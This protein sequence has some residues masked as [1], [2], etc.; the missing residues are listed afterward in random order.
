M[1]Y[2]LSDLIPRLKKYSATLDQ[3][4]FLVDKP[5]VVSDNN[6]E[7]EKLIFRRDGR[8]HLSSD[9]NV[10]DGTWEYLPEAQSLLIDYGDQKKLYQHQYLDESV[11]ALKLD[12]DRSNEDYFLLANENVIPDYD[13]KKYLKIK[14]LKENNIKLL[15]LEDGREI[16]LKPEYNG[17]NLLNAQAEINGQPVTDGVY[18]DKD[19]SNKIVVSSGKVSERK[20]RVNYSNNISVW[21]SSTLPVVGDKVEGI[22]TGSFEIKA[23]SNFTIYVKNGQITKVKDDT[24]MHILLFLLF[25]ILLFIFA[26]FLGQY[27]PK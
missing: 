22:S 9:G 27:L 18:T 12:G 4:S 20:R 23:G 8:V 17:D 16:F 15:P 2:Y 25:I 7:Y 26:I 21:Q 3:S 24:V 5:W 14:Y 1:K 19:Q 10:K 13:A 11:L 6:S